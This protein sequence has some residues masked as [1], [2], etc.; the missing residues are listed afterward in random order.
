L[1]ELK[2]GAELK[3]YHITVLIEPKPLHY[4]VG[5]YDTTEGRI[6]FRDERTNS[7]KN[8]P[9]ELCLIEEVKE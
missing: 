5:A 2:K 4:T 6:I 9:S 8:F 1:R 3:M 7:V